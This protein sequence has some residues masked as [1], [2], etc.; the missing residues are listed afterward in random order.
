VI[1]YAVEHETNIDYMTIY[2]GRMNLMWIGD[3]TVIYLVVLEM[4]MKH[5]I[6]YTTEEMNHMGGMRLFMCS[7]SMNP[8]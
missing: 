6:I 4:N 1:I 7:K 2:A 5:N 3:H 8:V